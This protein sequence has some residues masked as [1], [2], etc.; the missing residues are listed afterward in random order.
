[1]DVKKYLSLFVIIIAVNLVVSIKRKAD[2]ELA[3]TNNKR[4]LSDWLELSKE[5]LVLACNALNIS[6]TGSQDILAQ[7]LFV[8]YSESSPITPIAPSTTSI[9]DPSSSSTQTN[10]SSTSTANSTFTPPST[11]IPA[12]LNLQEVIRAEVQRCLLQESVLSRPANPVLDPTNGIPSF[13]TVDISQNLFQSQSIPASQPPVAS[14]GLLNFFNPNII[15]PVIDTPSTLP[16]VSFNQSRL[17][18]LPQAVIQQIQARKFVKFD[19]LLPAVSPLSSD[20][21]TIQVSSDCNNPTVS[22]IPKI[23][24][25]PSIVDFLT[26]MSAWNNFIQVLT[27]SHPHLFHDL[28]RYQ[29]LIT[30]FACQYSFS[31]W[32]TY[33]QLFRYH[34]ANDINLSWASVDDDLYNRYIR[35]GTLRPICYS[36]RQYGHLAANCP[37]RSHLS[38]STRQQPFLA[39]QRQPT[40]SSQHPTCRFFNQNEDCRIANCRFPHECRICYGNHSASKCSKNKR[41]NNH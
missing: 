33:D 30:R 23:Q 5:A 41:S 29:S 36:C 9:P 19:S 26:W 10:N 39:P 14:N 4:S 1:M 31:A 13:P 17:P 32:Y 28:M 21:Y 35:G 38:P 22:L 7:R 24:T 40:H 37:T 16:G 34:I 20:E 2:E 25:R 8:F 11:A 12:S 3:E 18:P 6:S 27:H 15:Q